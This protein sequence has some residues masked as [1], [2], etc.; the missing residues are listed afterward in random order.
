[1]TIA[2][3]AGTVAEGAAVAFALTAAPAPAADLVVSVTVTES[4]AMLARTGPRQVALAAGA[5]SATLTL[6]TVDDAEQEPDSTVTATVT[7]GSG[8]TLGAGMASANVLVTDDDQPP[9]LPVVTLAA[10]ADQVTEG[11]PARFTVSADR[12]LA[13]DLTVNVAVSESLRMLSG[14]PPASVTIRA[15]AAAAELTLETDDDTE[16]EEDSTVTVAVQPGNGYQVGVPDVAGVRVV[17]NDRV[18]LVPLFFSYVVFD[19]PDERVDPN[20]PPRRTPESAWP[21]RKLGLPFGADFV[22]ATGSPLAG[23]SAA[24]RQCVAL[25]APREPIDLER[26][27]ALGGTGRTHDVT[28]LPAAAGS[29][30]GVE[31]AAP[32]H[33]FRLWTDAAGATWLRDGRTCPPATTNGG[34]TRATP[35]DNTSTARGSSESRPWPTSRWR[36]WASWPAMPTSPPGRWRTRIRTTRPPTGPTSFPAGSIPTPPL[37]P[38][39]SGSRR[40]AVSGCR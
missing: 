30:N 11:T 32:G 3:A 25:A 13:A 10:A 24:H 23:A 22:N 27:L 5:G 39:R 2:A 19:E 36:G 21:A 34:S 38:T 12:T 35:P 9:P 40:A 28:L 6:A 17:D 29:M 4:G 26:W 15:G 1:M 16:V 14:T 20:A 18:P 31:Y 7:A 37:P 8:Y 33:G